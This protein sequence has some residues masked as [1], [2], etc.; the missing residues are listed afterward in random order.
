MGIPFS[1]D[2]A[3]QMVSFQ[4]LEDCRA[5]QNQQHMQHQQML[6]IQQD[7]QNLYLNPFYQYSTWSDT[8]TSSNV[9]GLL[10]VATLEQ[11]APAKSLNSWLD[12]LT[13]QVTTIGRHELDR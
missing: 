4:T 3:R 6:K 5:W 12:D 7:M 10:P 13:N 1:Y 2:Y 8:S 9:K 11:S